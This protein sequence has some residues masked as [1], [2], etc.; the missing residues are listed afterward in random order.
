MRDRIHNII[1]KAVK[2]ELKRFDCRRTYD[3][4]D[5]YF[6]SLEHIHA[7]TGSIDLCTLCSYLLV[8]I[9]E[10]KRLL[11]DNDKKKIVILYEKNQKEWDKRTWE[12][13]HYKSNWDNFANKPL[14]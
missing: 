7:E 5:V 3:I 13:I 9:M 10:K 8:A 6:C 1:E 12:Y 2:E 4:C 11:S 14:V